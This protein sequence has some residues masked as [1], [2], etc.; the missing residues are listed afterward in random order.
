MRFKQK[1]TQLLGF[2]TFRPICRAFWLKRLDYLF[3]IKNK[4]ILSIIYLLI[5]PSLVGL[6]AFYISF[7]INSN[8]HITPEWLAFRL[9][10]S[11]VLFM[12]ISFILGFL[13]IKLRINN[14][15][16]SIS[17]NYKF[18]IVLLISI[19]FTFFAQ[20][21]CYEIYKF[22]VNN[23]PVENLGFGIVLAINA[24]I[25][26]LGTFCLGLIV[27]DLKIQHK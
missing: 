25:V 6:S 22:L 26:F 5:V 16:K 27:I 21:V 3:F 10:L 15:G 17:Y 13:V 24:F 23:P 1:L 4:Y 11:I 9:T 2:I 20:K 19:C 7:L 8:L 14:T 12:E 18:L